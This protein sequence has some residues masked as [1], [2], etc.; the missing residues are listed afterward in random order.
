MRKAFAAIL[1]LLYCAP[2]RAQQK[3]VRFNTRDG[4]RI[5]A[6]YLAP[7]SSGAFVFINTHGLGSAK[8]E[9]GPL[10][11]ALK[12]RGYGYLSLDMRGHGQ[13]KTCGGKT[14]DYKTFTKAD[15]SKV[16]LDIEAAAAFLKKNGTAPGRII[17]CGASIGANLSLKAAAEGRIKP[18]ALVLLS[19]GLDYAGVRAGDFLPDSK[20][21]KLLISAAADDTYAWRSGGQL[22]QQARGKDLPAAFLDGGSGHG[23]NMFT[24]PATIPAIL[25][26]AAGL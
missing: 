25:A 9:W 5:E 17:F 19:P 18:R 22:T 23:A 16:S 24:T 26:W 15:W 14:A 12:K 6:A 20:Q 8:Y 3:T 4:C 7:A 21:V 2:A 10:Q 11:D 13:S 1:L